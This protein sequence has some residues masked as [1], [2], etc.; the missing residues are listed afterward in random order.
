MRSLAVLSLCAMLAVFIAGCSPATKQ[1]L[2]D[3]A[4]QIAIQ[5][6][7]PVA[8]QLTVLSL[9]KAAA[10]SPASTLAASQA[11]VTMLNTDLIPYFKGQPVM[12]AGAVKDLLNTKFSSAIP[13]AA[14]D[15][16]NF[17]T[18]IGSIVDAIQIPPDTKLTAN[19]VA[20]IVNG[21][22]GVVDGANAFIS[23]VPAPV[24]GS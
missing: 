19:E 10:K 5:G 17:A 1:A 20:I 14:A 24:S 7:Q 9:K 15:G 8:K 22:Q 18:T 3:D 2:K 23:S 12:A 13:A 6:A 21:L 16:L 11:L 4:T